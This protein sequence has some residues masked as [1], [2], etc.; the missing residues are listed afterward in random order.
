MKTIIVALLLA[1]TSLIAKPLPPEFLGGWLGSAKMNSSLTE[2]SYLKT[3][4]AIGSKKGNLLKWKTDGGVILPTSGFIPYDE[5][6][7]L[8]RNGKASYRIFNGQN[9]T[10]KFTGEWE[11]KKRTLTTKMV[12]PTNENHTI[13]LRYTFNRSKTKVSIQITE[14]FNDLISKTKGTATKVQLQ[15][16]PGIEDLN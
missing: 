3:Y 11:F 5:T 1:S 10:A 12:S 15:V 4:S 6:I 7:R 14:R 9:L 16:M 8:R 2:E 13:Q